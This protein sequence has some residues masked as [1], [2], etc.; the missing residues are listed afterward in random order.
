MVFTLGAEVAIGLIVMLL[1]LISPVGNVDAKKFITSIT[2]VDNPPPVN[3]EPQPIR[4]LTPPP[5]PPLEQIKTALKMP[6]PIL[7]KPKVE[8]DVTAPKIEVASKRPV[9]DIPP[10]KMPKALVKTGD[11]TTGSRHR[12]RLRELPRRCRR[13][14]SAIPTEFPRGTAIARLR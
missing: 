10:P 13:A 12:P 8:E 4:K 2:L 7:P 14:V 11:F 9:I 3:H 5:L 6:A 1:V